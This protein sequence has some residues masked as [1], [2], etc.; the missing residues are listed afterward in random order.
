MHLLRRLSTKSI[1][2]AQSIHAVWWCML[3]AGW[4]GRRL[5]TGHEIHDTVNHYI[6]HKTSQLSEKKNYD[7][8]TETPVRDD[9]SSHADGTI[10]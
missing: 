7:D 1:G 9:L 8:E 4:V 5:T 3:L 6:C 2:V 10:L